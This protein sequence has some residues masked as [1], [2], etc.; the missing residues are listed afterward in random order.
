LFDFNK[1]L[2]GLIEKKRL[3]KF[4]HQIS[5]QQFIL[6]PHHL[7]HFVKVV[8]IDSEQVG[9]KWHVTEVN[10]GFVQLDFLT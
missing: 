6:L 9:S 3:S 8:A 5:K 1:R 2:F 10:L 4:H 7:Q